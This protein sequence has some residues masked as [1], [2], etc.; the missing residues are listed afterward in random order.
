MKSTYFYGALLLLVCFS[1]EFLVF[2]EEVLVL[3]SFAIFIFLLINYGGEMIAS[4]L[5]SRKQKIKEE[6]DLYKN[7]QEK[8]FIHLIAYH[9]K[10]KLLSFEIKEIFEIS[11][12]EI[13]NIEKYYE[14]SLQNHLVFNFEERLKRV[15]T[16][17]NK[18]NLA[19]Q[20]EIFLEL[21][22]YLMNFYSV[23]SGMMTKKSKKQLFKSCVDQLKT[24]Y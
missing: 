13:F 7:L 8:T 23:E 22:S 1:K 4:E 21:K 10:Q 9:K 14:N 15:V 2:N 5:D 11:K 12:S 16:N 17:E 19:L 3:L 24:C 18:T 6:F 20:K